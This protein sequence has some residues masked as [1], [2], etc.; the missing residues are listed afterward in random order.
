MRNCGIQKV[1]F[2]LIATCIFFS[3]SG[4]TAPDG[5]TGTW[6]CVAK[7][8]PDGDLEFTLELR[9]SGESLTGTISVESGSVVTLRQACVIPG[10]PVV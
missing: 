10:T 2:L 4:L 7:G 1:L 9:Q 5:A 8:L 6:K 3:A